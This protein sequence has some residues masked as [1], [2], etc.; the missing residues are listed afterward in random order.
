M[1]EQME[2]EGAGSQA[3]AP[4]KTPKATA[5]Q[6]KESAK[7][8]TATI[9]PPP[10]KISA[11]VSVQMMAEQEDGQETNRPVDQEPQKPEFKDKAL[12][13]IH[14]SFDND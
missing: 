6:Q 2:D 14:N 5:D 9:A 13:S 4:S 11:D 3:Q 1:K 10:V 8:P 7:D 12:D